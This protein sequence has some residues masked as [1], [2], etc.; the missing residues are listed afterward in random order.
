MP[1]VDMPLEKLYDYKGSSPCP[2]DIDE[3]WNDA[4]SEADNVY[5]GEQFIKKEFK[6]KIADFYDLYFTGTKGAKIHAQFGK[7]K[8][9]EAPF[10]AVLMFHGLS[11]RGDCWSELLKYISQGFCVAFM[12]V[13]GQGGESEDRGN[14]KGSTYST[15]FTRG[16]DGDKHDLLMRDVFL[17]TVLL[18]KILMKLD[19]VDEN[20]IGV[21]GA[22]QGGGLSIACAALVPEIKKCAPVYPYLSDYKR[23]WSMDLCGAGYEG[24]RY[25]FKNF[26]PRHANEDKFF[27]KLGYIDIQNI[28]HRIKSEV[29]MATALMD[30]TCPPSSQFA[31]YNKIASKKQIEIY[32]DFGHERLIGHDD[33]IFEFLSDL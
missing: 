30:N 20:R 33:L 21:T 10:P 8:N 26:D 31:A 22:S 11:G 5:T 1:V 2:A 17:D 12:D 24:I 25:Y 16:I 23:V 19:Y 15:P 18:A 7:P 28:A 32:P 29:Y 4:L 27:E 9:A 3:Y 13:R 6:S 14:V